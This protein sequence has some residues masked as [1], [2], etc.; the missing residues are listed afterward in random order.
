[1]KRKEIFME[2]KNNYE[3]P[4]AEVIELSNQDIVTTSDNDVIKP[5]SLDNYA[6]NK[7]YQP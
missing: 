5:Y 1:M 4:E 7:Y 3:A 2:I 6:A